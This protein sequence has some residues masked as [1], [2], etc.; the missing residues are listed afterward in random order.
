M[1]LGVFV[2]AESSLFSSLERRERKFIVGVK[3]KLRLNCPSQELNLV[4][5][6][7]I[8]VILILKICMTSN[9]DIILKDSLAQKF[10]LG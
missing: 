5:Y 6:Y 8:L 2:T 7:K 9:F 4:G 10:R 1:S 3:S